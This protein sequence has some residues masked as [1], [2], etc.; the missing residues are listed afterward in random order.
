MKKRTEYHREHYAKNAEKRREQKQENND[1]FD[2]AI[3]YWRCF[4]L[5]GRKMNA[6]ISGA[7]DELVERARLK[8]DEIYNQ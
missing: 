2:R 5:Y 6:L 1:A 7:S 4:K 8:Y 3:S